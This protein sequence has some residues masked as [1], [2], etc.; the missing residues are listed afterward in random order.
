MTAPTPVDRSPVRFSGTVA[1]ASAFAAALAVGVYA[2]LALAVGVPGVLLLVAGTV[3]GT[4]WAVTGGAV[5][6]FGSVLLAGAR[7]APP[8]ALLVGTVTAVLA[9]DGAGTAIDL[10]EQLGRAAPSRRL[11]AVHLGAT[12]LVGLLA[13]IVGYG[14]YRTATGGQPVAALVF[15][16][17][18][19]VLLTETLS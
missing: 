16:L 12:A 19:A 8:L 3:R 11:Q 1:I 17:V 4:R 14:L 13:T 18:A 6:L 7:G 15:L 10:G 9:W 2:P 5:V